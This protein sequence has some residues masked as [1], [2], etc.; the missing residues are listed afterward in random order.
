MT[1]SNKIIVAFHIGRGGR[2]NNSG[3]VSFLGEKNFQELIQMN[4]NELFES[5]KDEYGKFCKPYLH[6]NGNHVT[7]DDIQGEIGEL[8]FDHGYDTDYCKYLDDCSENE[9]DVVVNTSEYKSP[10]LCE[11]LTEY[12]PSYKF[13][14]YGL[15]TDEEV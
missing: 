3:H 15:L 8:N 10:D 11:W 5:N 6:H 13:D 9:I 2:F 12:N 1:T 14:K 7:D 4:S